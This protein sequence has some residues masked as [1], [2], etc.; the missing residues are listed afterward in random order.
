M[1]T[2]RIVYRTRQFWKALQSKPAE[3][4]LERIGQAL[5]PQ[6]MALFTRLQP[7]EQ[8]HS[9]HVYCKLIERGEDHPDLL[10]AALLHDSGKSLYPLRLWERVA[11]VLAKA[12]APEGVKRWGSSPVGEKAMRSWR[13]PFLIAEQHPA[14]GA[15]L[16]ARAGASLLAVSL[17]R[18]HQENL[19]CVQHGH[20]ERG[21]G[22]PDR[23][24]MADRSL[25]DHYL[26]ILQS[27][28][29]ES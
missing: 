14:W 25:E 4:D 27:V 5:A 16:A 18:R 7:G 28:D 26:S 17:I 21:E 29:D 10:T 19:R 22:S 11:I 12:L 13:R 24:D 15:E 6:Q 23:G 1:N 8:A 2:A 9:I 20:P 3:I